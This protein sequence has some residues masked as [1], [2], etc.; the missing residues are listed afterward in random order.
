MEYYLTSCFLFFAVECYLNEILFE[1]NAIWMEYHLNVIEITWV[2]CYLS[3]IMN[4]ILFECNCEWNELVC[5]HIIFGQCIIA[6]TAILWLN[7]WMEYYLSVIGM[8]CLLKWIVWNVI[9]IICVNVIWIFKCNCYWIS[10]DSFS[11]PFLRSS[12]AAS[13]RSVL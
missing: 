7:V 8:E 10:F 9:E 6:Q 13:A 11:W 3:V 2:E 1:W 4:G 5:P 12:E